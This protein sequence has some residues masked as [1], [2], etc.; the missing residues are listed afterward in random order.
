MQ[1]ELVWLWRDAGFSALLVTH[2]VEEALVL[3]DRVVV[4]S[5]RPARMLAEFSVG[6]ERPRRR[7]DPLV[8][9]LRREILDLLVSHAPASA[10]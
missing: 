1:D 10:A 3:A 9:S 5:D 7:D 2:D 6:A 8:V 4:L